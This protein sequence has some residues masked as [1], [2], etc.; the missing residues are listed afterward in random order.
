MIQRIQTVYMLA[1]VIAILMMLVMPLGTISANDAYFNV[2]ALGITSVTQDVP[3]DKMSYGLVTLLL[4]MMGLPLICIFLYK[5]R[6][7]QLRVLIYTAV[8]DVL[9]YG[10]FFLYEAGAMLSSAVGALA[11]NNLPTEVVADY[12]FTLYAMPVVSLFCC[13]MAWRGV[14]YDIA[15][16]SS[17]DRLRPSRKK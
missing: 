1:S 8:L 9:F 2:S 3:L 14:T 10:Y 11:I 16:I 13:V 5:K 17:A 6:K 15:L 7:L 12:T 4:L